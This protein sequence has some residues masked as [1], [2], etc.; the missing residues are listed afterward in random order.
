MYP[1]LIQWIAAILFGL[2]I[3][4]V[5]L[6]KYFRHFAGRYPKGSFRENLF[7]LLGE[8]EIVFG[9]WAGILLLIFAALEGV[10]SAIAYLESRT[11]TE[12]VFIFAIL[13]VC[14]TRAILDCAELIL[15]RIAEQLPVSRSIAF[16]GSVLTIGPLLGSL[17]TEPA[18]MTVVAI[19]LLEYYYRENISEKLKYET[20]GLLFVNVS[21]G[22]ALTSYAAPPVLMVARAWGW[23][24]WEMFS[25]FGWKGALACLISTLIMT[26]RY[27]KELLKIEIPEKFR[28]IRVP[29]W[30]KT[31]H[32]IFLAAIVICS[33]HALLVIG[34]FLFF[35]GFVHVTREYQESIR[36]RQGLLVS[37]FLVGLVVIGGL[38]NW[39]IELIIYSLSS[40]SLY[41]SA[42]VL[43]AFIDNAA[44]TY[45]GSLVPSLLD[46]SKYALLAGAVVG[47]GLTVIAN[48]PNLAGYS[49]LQPA[50]KREGI[51]P[52]GLL[53]A[54]FMPT[55][56]AAFCFW[57]F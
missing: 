34:L 29:L 52:I 55:S 56:V 10:D 48:A 4:H 20:L 18:A 25:N 54:A 21:I 15:I 39:W 40:F 13:I 26:F 45:L 22:G 32:L 44:L 23:G 51:S 47:G 19:I 11:F 24:S 27:R 35:L 16:Y 9:L 53:K 8:V 28:Q 7:E 38:Q 1:T 3:L 49:I 17:I 41:L 2:S 37:F 12:P 46:S 30:V 33:H 31:A 5:F 42:I 6:V 14:S 50:F 43:T 57:I 36:L